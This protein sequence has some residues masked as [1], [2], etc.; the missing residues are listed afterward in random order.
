MILKMFLLHTK[1]ISGIRIK[2]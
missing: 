1:Q 2:P